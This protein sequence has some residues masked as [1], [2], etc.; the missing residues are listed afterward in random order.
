MN[1]YKKVIL[2][3]NAKTYKLDNNRYLVDFGRGKDELVILNKL[4]DFAHVEYV[5]KSDYIKYFRRKDVIFMT[6]LQIQIESKFQIEF[7]C[8]LTENVYS[9]DEKLNKINQDLKNEYAKYTKIRKIKMSLRTNIK[10]FINIFNN[11][12]IKNTEISELENLNLF[13]ENTLKDIKN[14]EFKIKK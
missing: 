5:K 3:E 2:K 1:E 13:L 11:I 8:I 7:F 4:N 10:S 14:K 9:Y 6:L 12:D